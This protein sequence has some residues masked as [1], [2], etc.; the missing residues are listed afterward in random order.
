MRF[1]PSSEPASRVLHLQQTPQIDD[2]LSM[3]NHKDAP[4][5]RCAMKKFNY[6]LFRSG[7]CT[8][9]DLITMNVQNAQELRQWGCD[10]RNF[11]MTGELPSVR[12]ARQK[13]SVLADLHIVRL[14]VILTGSQNKNGPENVGSIVQ[15]LELSDR[16]RTR[17]QSTQLS[18]SA[19]VI[20]GL[21]LAM[22]AR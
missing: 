22:S 7:R 19:F 20:Q 17:D 11:K 5:V 4:K 15:R 2:V 6:R 9:K 13:V 1:L 21:R 10:H 14:V 3:T 12:V 16:S 18:H 8:T